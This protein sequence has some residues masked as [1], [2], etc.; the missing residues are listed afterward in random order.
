VLVSG[1]IRGKGKPPTQVRMH[2]WRLL[3]ASFYIST[4]VTP[5]A[6]PSLSPF[7]VLKMDR[8]PSIVVSHEFRQLLI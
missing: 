6:D 4:M 5:A 8:A 3:W 7:N 2:F 1:C